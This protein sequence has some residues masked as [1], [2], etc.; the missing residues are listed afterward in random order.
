MSSG[1]SRWQDGR[2][3]W[4]R[5]SGWHQDDP[6]ASPGHPDDAGSALAALTDIGFLRHLLDQ[7][8]LSA[9]RTARRHRTSWAEIATKLGV[10][11]QSAWE[12]W[13]ELDD[14]VATPPATSPAVAATA[15]AAAALVP[16]QVSDV[17]RDRRRRSLVVVPNVI[18]MTWD[19]ARQALQNNRLIAVG[20]DQDGPPLAALGWPGGVVTDQSPESGAKVPVGSPVTLW[21]ERG[22][23]SGVREPRRPSPSPRS[24]REM[25]DEPS[26]ESVA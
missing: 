5:L 19:D 23:G 25:R 8:E 18:G 17:A 12:R 21:V 9:V 10:T 6:S 1:R 14:D 24:G 15:A 20:P 4:A 3:V 11:R 26:N 22:G 16:D 2:R 13:R 7:A